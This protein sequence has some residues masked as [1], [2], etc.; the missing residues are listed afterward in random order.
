M[1]DEV[2]ALQWVERLGGWAV[3]LIIVR[4][5]MTR[6]DSLINGFTSALESFRTFETEERQM[7]SKILET[8]DTIIQVQE[9]ILDTVKK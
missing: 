1:P 5:M 7:H 6:I 3:V 2:N 4:W 8:Q 9:R